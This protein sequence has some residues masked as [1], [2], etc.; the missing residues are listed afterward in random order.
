MTAC[1]CNP[2]AGVTCMLHFDLDRW[3]LGGGSLVTS[4][5]KQPNVEVTGK[6]EESNDN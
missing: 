6:V 1:V 4:E 5:D 2:A 3:L